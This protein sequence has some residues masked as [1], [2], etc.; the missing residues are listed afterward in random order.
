MFTCNDCGKRFISK[1]SLTGH[2]RVHFLPSQQHQQ[3]LHYAYQ[4]QQQQPAVLQQQVAAAA[5]SA[6]SPPV[7]R[8]AKRTHSAEE[9]LMHVDKLVETKVGREMDDWDGGTGGLF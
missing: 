2:R 1:H 4:Q 7:D 3:A 9:E 8:K 5:A 6:P